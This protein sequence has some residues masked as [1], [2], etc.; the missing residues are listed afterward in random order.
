M[1]GPAWRR[2]HP[3]VNG[4]R[5]AE[6]RG[7]PPQSSMEH[8][9]PGWPVVLETGPRPPGRDHELVGDAGGEG[10]DEHRL[11][12]DGHDANPTADLLLDEVREE[13]APHRAGGIGA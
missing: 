8:R 1:L 11:V 10:R 2:A 3:D 9:R 13:V 12:V 5:L 7:Q 6:A 4:R